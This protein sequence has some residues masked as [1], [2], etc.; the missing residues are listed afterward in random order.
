MLTIRA[1][2]V[3]FSDKLRLDEMEKE[4]GESKLGYSVGDKYCQGKRVRDI[5]RWKVS[6]HE[7]ENFDKCFDS[8]FHF[9][10]TN[11]DSIDKLR[12]VCDVRVSFMLSSNNGQ[13]G[14]YIPSDIVKK[15]QELEIDYVFDAYLNY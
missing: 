15:M 8:V 9:F 4:L 7:E 1:S 11:K 13:G 5:N 6:F 3:I 14:F 2:I 10:E 12:S